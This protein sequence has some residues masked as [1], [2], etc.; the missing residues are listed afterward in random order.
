MLRA[1]SHQPALDSAVAVRVTSSGPDASAGGAGPAGRSGPAGGSELTRRDD[2]AGGHGSAASGVPALREGTRVESDAAD[3][4]RDAEADPIGELFRS[5]AARVYGYV[6]LRTTADLADDVVADTFVTAWRLRESVPDDPL[7]WLLVIARNALANRQRSARR[8]TRLVV[9][10]ANVDRLAHHAAA[11]EDIAVD[12]AAVLA[13]LAGLRPEDREALLLVA[14]DGLTTA[15]AA[16]VAGCSERT[17]ARRLR[18]ARS[19]LD[20]AAFGHQAAPDPADMPS[21]PNP[22]E[23]SR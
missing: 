13:A 8:G 1:S 17:F 15:D 16:A 12:R 4:P 20:A 21:I 23:D 22:S 2:P 19:R 11:A 6:R 5:F 14:W 10:M 3:R 18:R 7:R 9:A